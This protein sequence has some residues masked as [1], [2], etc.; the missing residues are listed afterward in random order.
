[1][2]DDSLKVLECSLLLAKIIGIIS[3]MNTILAEIISLTQG[4]GTQPVATAVPGLLVVKGDIPHHQLATLYRPVI[5][6]T[7]QGTKI[8]S[9]DGQQTVLAGPAYYVL[10]VHVPAT[11]RVCP[12]AYGNPYISMGFHIDATAL[13]QLLRDI[14]E[15][16]L[17]RHPVPLAACEL[18]DDMLAVWLRLLRL[19]HSP[20][21]VP[22]L[23]PAYE[24]E[25][26][27][28]VLIGPHGGTLR[29][30]ASAEN[31]FSKISQTIQ[32]LR[33]NYQHP[34]E[35]GEIADAAGMAIN[36][37]HRHF[38]RI[39]GLSPIQY[40]KQLRLM[41]ARNLIAFG[42]YSVVDAAYE[43]GYQSPSQFN[44][45]YGRFFGA[46]PAKDTQQLRRIEQ[47]R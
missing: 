12:D 40:Q 36:T 6:F 29:Q 30:L 42:G 17:P 45:E 5:G 44:R 38:K 46:P 26:L 18:D 47:A 11:A 21:D 19:G 16:L 35:I 32:T 9:V 7:V 33:K 8:F 1:L 28:R 3:N 14:P 37:F 34:V 27:Y 13:Q 41:E 2:L 23:A 20:Q 31:N 25:L 24:R 15:S 22:A 10:P 43:V 39:T 4:V